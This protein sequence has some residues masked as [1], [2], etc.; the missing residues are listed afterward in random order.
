[1]TA[2]T[3]VVD[4]DASLVFTAH[5][6]SWQAQ[7]KLRE[8]YGGAV[9]DLTGWRL[10]A[11]GLEYSYLNAA[12][13]TDPLAADVEAARAWYA[14][15]KLAWGAIVP[16]GAS[17]PHGRHLLTIR[18]M[19]TAPASFS[20]AP[21]PPGLVLRSAGPGRQDLETL[22][23]IDNG[24]FGS[25]PA[26]ARAWLAPLCGSEAA[27]V[28]IGELEGVPVAAGYALWCDGE[29]GQSLY[30]GGIGVLPRARRRGVA[31]ALLSRLVTPG[32]ER[33]AR[34]AHLQTD[35]DNAARVY[36]RLGFEHFGGIDIY[37][38]N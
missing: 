14:E 37:V 5:A 36:E 12:C 18:L 9:A 22:V 29:A 19:A 15:R 24:A 3:S 7:G 30:L 33:G 34:F 17:W 27:E 16:S 38:E 21:A 4:L 26:P 23:A 1:M 6:D 28:A 20:R 35:A 2:Y 13:V 25:A 11:S 10:M 8:L 32:F 31:S